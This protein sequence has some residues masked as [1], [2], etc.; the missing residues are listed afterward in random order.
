MVNVF[1][2]H[3]ILISVEIHVKSCIQKS[4]GEQ[5]KPGLVKSD[6][7]CCDKLAYIKVFIFYYIFFGKLKWLL[8]IQ[9]HKAESFFYPVKPF[10]N[11]L[12]LTK[13][14]QVSHIICTST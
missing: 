13:L 6:V 3:K 12:K 7:S 4:R 9:K 8:F 11:L 1:F 2:Y 14:Q 10:G 5:I